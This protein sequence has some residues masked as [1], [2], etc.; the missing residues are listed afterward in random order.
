[1]ACAQIGQCSDRNKRHKVYFYIALHQLQ[2]G[3]FPTAAGMIQSVVIF[4]K[5]FKSV[6]LMFRI[7]WVIFLIFGV[8][9]VGSVLLAA[10][11]LASTVIDRSRLLPQRVGQS[12]II[13]A[14][15]WLRV[16]ARGQDVTALALVED[17]GRA[18]GWA[19]A[20]RN[21]DA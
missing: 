19:Y 17:R 18:G 21:D 12:A 1:M 6:P 11:D 2:Y 8:V 14:S 16:P 7:E 13:V 20:Q 5:R 15:S 4:V 9:V 10:R 3:F